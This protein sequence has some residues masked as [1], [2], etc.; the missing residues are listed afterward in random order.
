MS[1]SSPPAAEPGLDSLSALIK[2][3]AR[4]MC[5]KHNHKGRN[6]TRRAHPR[7]TRSPQRDTRRVW[8]ESSRSRSRRRQSTSLFHT[9]PQ[10]R[11]PDSA[12]GPQRRCLLAQRAE[13]IGTAAQCPALPRPPPV[14]VTSPSALL[15]HLLHGA[16]HHSLGERVHSDPF[17]VPHGSLRSLV[18]FGA[19]DLLS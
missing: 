3:N 17:L 16:L 19:N 13:P 1:V 6:R 4:I 7:G 12:S 2:F 11:T 18:A 8:G 10:T 14:C 5:D 9:H 15:E